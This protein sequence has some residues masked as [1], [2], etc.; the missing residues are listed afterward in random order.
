MPVHLGSMPA[1]VSAAVAGRPM[2]P[3]DVV[4]LNDPFAGGTHLPDITLVAPVHGSS[5]EL[6]FYVAARAH[7]ADVGGATPGSM[8]LASDV[9]GEGLRIPPVRLVRGGR[10]DDDM[11]RLLLANM[12][13]PEEREGDIAAQVGAMRTG[14]A[15]L[16]EVVERYGFETA[17]RYAEALIEYTARRMR[18]C[19]TSIP[20]GT[21]SAEDWLDDD[22]AGG[23][24]VRIAVEIT[25]DGDRARVDFAGSSPQRRGPVN[26][27][28]SITLSAVYY[29]F[30]T[31]LDADVPASA[32]VL[33]PIEVVAPEGSVVNA[34]PPAPVAGGNVETSQRIVDAL[35]RA[36]AAALPERVP[37]AS[38]G[39]MNNLTIG[40]LDPRTGRQ[41]S[42]YETVG[43][44]MGARPATDGLDAVHTHMT[45]SL[46]TPV[47]ALEYAYP[48]R[49]VRYGVRR[50]SGGAGAR[51]GGDGIVR[52][53]ELLADA[54]VSILSDRRD[55]A[56]YGLAGGAPGSPGRN[57][58]ARARTGAEELPGVCSLDL[59][60]GDR[61]RIETPGGGGH[62]SPDGLLQ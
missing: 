38:Q 33:D 22:G 54:R 49:V 17:D 50:G 62:G 58:V 48:L 10:A 2:E 20:D 30:R 16:A 44:G 43:G 60:A 18:A 12:R 19:I 35:Y 32:G 51:R 42:Y 8:G 11:R 45:N 3:G 26:A 37:A 13:G 56:P 1:A 15:R 53:V 28:A 14:A 36:L 40:G 55:R 27:V 52:E 61:V 23:G 59:K 41:F 7:H 5:G 47:E 39:T 6:M 46:N 25:V 4:A 31:L 34:L 57:S 21:Y 24:P 29:V 9:Y